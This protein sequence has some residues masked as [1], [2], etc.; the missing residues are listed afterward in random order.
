MTDRSD[1]AIRVHDLVGTRVVTA[2]DRVLGRVVDLEITH[3]HGFSIVA[4]EV[5]RFGLLDRIGILRI[6]GLGHARDRAPRTVPWSSVERLHDGVVRLR[7][8]APERTEGGAEETGPAAEN[9]ATAT[10]A[11][12]QSEPRGGGRDD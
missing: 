3:D 12:R 6:L 11:G 5:G 4:L 1:A 8:G 10:S 2:D 9:S 7:A